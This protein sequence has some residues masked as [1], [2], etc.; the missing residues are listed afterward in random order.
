M[1]TWCGGRL[2][3]VAS[4][5]AMSPSGSVRSCRLRTVLELRSRRKYSAVDIWLS[6]QLPTMDS[7]EL[8]SSPPPN[9]STNELVTGE[10]TMVWSSRTMVTTMMT[11]NTLGTASTL[12]RADIKI[13]Y[14]LQLCVGMQ[15]KAREERLR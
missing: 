11:T 13:L 7:L 8:R 3:V 5:R 14:E 15:G 6:H 4:A 12:L 9:W 2:H 10:S 1:Y